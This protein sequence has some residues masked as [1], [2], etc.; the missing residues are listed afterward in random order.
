MNVIPADIMGVCFG[1]RK[2]L[3]VA[4]RIDRPETVTILGALVHNEAVQER[5]AS[6]GFQIAAERNRRQLPRTPSVLITAH[7]VSDLRRHRLEAA[8]KRLIDTTCPLVRR[9]QHKARALAA[10]GYH[11]LLRCWE[12]IHRMWQA[13]AHVRTIQFREETRWPGYYFRV[14]KPT[15]DN[16]NWLAFCNCKYDRNTG[17]WEMIKRPVKYLTQ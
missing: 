14:D 15:M 2:A 6:R 3:A 8:G 4:E 12:N 13:E 9:V 17:D 10:E 5:L 16:E 1:V 7:G 11:E